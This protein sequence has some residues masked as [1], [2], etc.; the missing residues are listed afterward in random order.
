MKRPVICKIKITVK[1]LA[2]LT[3][4]WVK[5]WVANDCTA[6]SFSAG[7]ILKQPKYIQ[8]AT[9]VKIVPIESYLLEVDVE[10]KTNAD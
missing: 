3:P 6:K 2:G 7:D 8:E 1:Q 9:V 10:V 4:G 5:L